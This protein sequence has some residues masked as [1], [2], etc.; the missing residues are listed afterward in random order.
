MAP[1]QLS[2]KT[3]HERTTQPGNESILERLSF[4]VTRGVSFGSK[5][6]LFSDGFFTV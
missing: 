2:I 1:S 4:P 6:L 5:A 3:C